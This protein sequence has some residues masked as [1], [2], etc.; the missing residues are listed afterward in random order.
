MKKTYLKPVI[1]T[2]ELQMEGNLLSGSDPMA[3]SF[4]STYNES[5]G[6][7]SNG[8]EESGFE[9]M[10]KGYDFDLFGDE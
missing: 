8:N 4:E 6:T 3:A 1:E 2:V 9:Q 7:I 5:V 10:A